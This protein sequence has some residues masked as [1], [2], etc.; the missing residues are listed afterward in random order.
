MEKKLTKAQRKDR[1]NRSLCKLVKENDLY[2][3]NR[4]L[5]E[6]EGLI[7]QVASSI[8]LLYDIDINNWGGVEKEDIIQEGRIAMLR[9]AQTYDE[10]GDVKF[11]TYAYTVMENA[12]KDLCRKGISAFEKRMI[13]SGLAQ[14]FLDDEPWNPTD[15]E[16]DVLLAEKI[17]SSDNPDPTGNLAVLHVM[18]EKMRNRLAE[19][20]ARERRLLSFHFG[21]GA[22]DCRTISETA[23]YFHLTEK[24]ISIIEK[25]A[26]AKLREGMNDGKIV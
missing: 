22:L 20:P 4:L 14:V 7:V 6:N 9:A 2:A 15:G 16:D 21:L 17:K 10:D 18:L 11:S 3:E 8:E 24:Y 5:L 13:D 26:L 25:G 23:A 12:M 19:L 1:R